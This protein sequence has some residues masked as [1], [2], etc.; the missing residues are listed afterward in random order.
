M[1]L[2]LPVMG[3]LGGTGPCPKP[4]LPPHPLPLPPWGRTVPRWVGRDG[5]PNHL[6]SLFCPFQWGQQ[7][8]AEKVPSHL[9]PRPR[10]PGPHAALQKPG[11]GAPPPSSVPC[12][13]LSLP[14][15]WSEQ[16]HGLEGR[17]PQ[18]C[19]CEWTAG[20]GADTGYYEPVYSESGIRSARPHCAARPGTGAGAP[21]GTVLG[22]T[23]LSSFTWAPEAAP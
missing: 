6:S 9:H 22:P 12:H 14:T 4:R 3:T 10:L 2:L 8:A 1:G 19:C 16:D 20:E 23:V 7:A 21:T 15:A 11:P 13:L 17:W 18:P 5:N